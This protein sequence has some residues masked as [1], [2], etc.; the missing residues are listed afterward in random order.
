M[1]QK[2]LCRS[3]QEWMDIIQE[4]RTSGLTDKDWCEQH[5]INRSKF[6]YHIRMLRK[7][8]CEIPVAKR[9]NRKVIQ[10]T[11]VPLTVQDSGAPSFSSQGLPADPVSSVADIS[12][13]AVRIHFHDLQI[14]LFNGADSQVV[15]DTLSVLYNLC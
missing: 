12:G 14:E 11:V 15:R 2:N 7:K 8:A 1:V 5:H 6:Y 10:Q 3:D 4:C 9:S 13:A